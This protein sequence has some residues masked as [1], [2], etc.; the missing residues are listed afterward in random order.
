MLLVAAFAFAGHYM[1]QNAVALRVI[2]R[3]T[4][5][6][7]ACLP[8]RPPSRQGLAARVHPRARGDATV[9]HPRAGI[10]VARKGDFL[11]RRFVPSPRTA[12]ETYGRK[13]SLAVSTPPVWKLE[14][15]FKI[16]RDQ[17]QKLIAQRKFRLA[18]ENCLARAIYFEARSESELGQLAV[19]KV[20]LNR[21]KDP[22]LSED[23]LRRRLSGLRPPATPASS[24]SPATGSATRSRTGRL[25]PLQARR[26]QAPSPATS[27]STVIGAATNYHADYV[28]AEM[29][30]QHEAPHQDRPAHLLH[31]LLS[32]HRN[33]SIERAPDRAL[34]VFCGA[35]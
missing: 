14:S 4:K 22:Q 15:S 8:P 33:F 3:R 28:H 19:A 10:L 1:G 26:P 32:S 20:I 34:F 16:A 12:D 6:P 24:P 11:G 31:Q 29:V 25:G 2:F 7:I 5:S 18:E 30:A 23:H 21:V 13:G 17:K 27:R 35:R 9:A